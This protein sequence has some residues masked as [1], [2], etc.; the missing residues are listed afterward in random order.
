MGAPISHP[1]A[2]PKYESTSR[3]EVRHMCEDCLRGKHSTCHSE[4]CPCVC[5]DSDFRWVRKAAASP[6]VRRL[7]SDAELAQ[8][9]EVRP[10]L[11][12]LFGMPR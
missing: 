11:R 2:G 6:E 3:R 5:N 4:G 7:T 9:L 10:D 12:P 8:V 1:D